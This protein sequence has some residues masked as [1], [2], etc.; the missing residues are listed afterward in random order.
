VRHEGCRSTESW[1]C[2]R[3]SRSKATV[4]FENVEAQVQALKAITA[5]FPSIEHIDDGM[6]TAP[7][8]RIINVIPAYEGRKSSA[9][10]DIAAYIGVPVIRAECPHFDRSLTRLEKLDWA[11]A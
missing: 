2:S 9:G 5:Q 10:P 8:K 6:E 4:P 11:E 3:K 1:Q 7:S